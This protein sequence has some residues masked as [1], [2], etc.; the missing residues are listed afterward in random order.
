[1]EKH[2]L[3]RRGFLAGTAATGAIAALTL[4]GCGGGDQK[5]DEPKKDAPAE[6]TVADSITAAV[7][8]PSTNCNPIGNS[9]ALML[10]ATWHVFEGLYDIDLQNY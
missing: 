1:M 4:S 6:K 8:Y 10:A 3:T 5:K 7:A 9:S 2:S